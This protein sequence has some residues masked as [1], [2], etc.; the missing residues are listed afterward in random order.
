MRR[1]GRWW[2]A[3]GVAAAGAAL[4]GFAP[5][6]DAPPATGLRFE[7]TV[8]PGLLPKPTDGRLLVVLGGERA[9]AAP[10]RRR[11]RD[12]PRQTIGDTG[13]T[14]PPLLGADVIGFAPG[15]VGLA[16]RSSANLPIAT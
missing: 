1:H 6:A 14:A 11:N 10:A 5:A 13:M 9:G 4:W 16:D 2:V 3:L 7:V 15:V 12:E 8:A